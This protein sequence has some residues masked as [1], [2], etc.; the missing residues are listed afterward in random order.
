S[1]ENANQ[2][3]PV[4]TTHALIREQTDK[5]S[6]A[7]ESRASVAKKS[8]VLVGLL[9]VVANIGFV[10]WKTGSKVSPTRPLKIETLTEAGQ[11]RHVAISPD[12]KFIAYTRNFEKKANIWLRQLV[13]DANIE[14][15]PV[16]D[17]IVGL[18]FS[19]SGEYLYFCRGEPCSLYRVPNV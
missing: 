6:D 9:L 2:L 16:G 14:I 10:L 4:M 3:E 15:V 5:T 17:K 8:I 11:S 7:P 1:P 19:N 18:A 13:T 12:G